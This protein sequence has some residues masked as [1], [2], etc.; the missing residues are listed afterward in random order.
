MSEKRKKEIRDDEAQGNAK[1]VEPDVKIPR[2]LSRYLG[3]EPQEET[4]FNISNFRK[5]KAVNRGEY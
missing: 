5:R 1:V 4:K 3:I 2:E